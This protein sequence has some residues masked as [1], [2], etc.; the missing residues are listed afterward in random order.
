MIVCRLH[1]PPTQ[2]WWARTCATVQCSQGLRDTITLLL[3]VVNVVC[4]VCVPPPPPKPGTV[5]CA[6]TSHRLSC[7][8]W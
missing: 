8:C 6:R 4:S 1:A 3:A 7:P 5:L 2:H